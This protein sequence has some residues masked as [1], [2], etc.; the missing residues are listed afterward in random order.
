M[1][2]LS[3]PIQRHPVIYA[4]SALLIIAIVFMVAR[5][6]KPVSSLIAEQDR[7]AMP[8]ITE[9]LLNG[10]P[11]KLRDHHGEV[12]A[13]NYWASWCAPC[14][15]ETPVL[16]KLS[17][18]LG[19]RGFTVIGIATD[20]RNSEEIPDGVNGFVERFH[21]PYAVAV[22]A[23]MSQIAYGM[24]GL[25]TTL[26]VDRQGRLAQVYA[27]AIRETVFRS[28]VETLLRDIQSK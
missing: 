27:G 12:I 19:P 4:A 3:R 6:R 17:R 23:P 9:K 25:P 11:W 5:N 1:R 22:T 2:R 18:E 14:W 20:E 8:A 7:R 21:I 13:I 24:E 10:E 28:D 26:L 15:Q 16:V